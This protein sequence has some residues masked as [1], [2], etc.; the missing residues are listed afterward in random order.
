M[1]QIEDI[2]AF[3]SLVDKNII[4][5]QLIQMEKIISIRSFCEISGYT[6]D[7]LLGKK[8]QYFKTSRY[9]RIYFY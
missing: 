8:S 4:K 9:A 7:E 3:N 1:K 6:K 5:Q 2:N